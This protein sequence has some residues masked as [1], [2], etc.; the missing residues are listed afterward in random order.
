MSDM[1]TEA[2]E[3]VCPDA[4]TP[5]PCYLV[6]WRIEQFYGGP[7]EG[8]WYGNDHIVVKYRQF[9]TIEAAEAVKAQVEALAERLTAEAK[10]ER[11]AAARRACEWA[12]ARGEDLE[13]PDDDRWTDAD[14]YYVSV[15]DEPPQNREQDRHWE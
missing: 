15:T 12:E 10:A 5:Q 7:E 6:L 2:F 11:N 14:R 8:G 13:G 9:D 3:T 4:S 1:I